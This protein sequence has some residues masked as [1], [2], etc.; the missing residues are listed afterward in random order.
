MNGVRNNVPGRRNRMCEDNE[1]RWRSEHLR[2]RKG[3]GGSESRDEV[4][5]VG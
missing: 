2:K 5:E 4:G 3:P 1:A